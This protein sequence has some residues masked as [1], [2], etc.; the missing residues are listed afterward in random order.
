MT[1]QVQL[2]NLHGRY[3]AKNV[4]LAGVKSV[5]IYDPEPVQLRDLGTQVSK[6]LNLIYYENF[7][8][9]LPS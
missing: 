3:S 2:T 4:V 8:H 7:N 1:F 6:R 9:Y 5:T